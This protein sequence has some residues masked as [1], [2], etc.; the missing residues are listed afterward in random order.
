M[1]VLLEVEAQTLAEGREWTRQRLEERLQAQADQI[2]ALCPQSG[3]VL[4]YVR[5][6]EFS[7][8]T[9]V[10]TVKVRAA[11]GFSSAM[12]RWLS[13]A[14][15]QWGLSPYERVSP[16]LQQKL[17]Y[18]ATQTGSYQKAALLAGCW[19]TTI[20]DDLVHSQVQSVGLQAEQSACDGPEP[21]RSTKNEAPFSLVIMLDGWMVRERGPQ[22]AAPP[23]CQDAQRV[24][25]HEVKSGVI[26]RLDHQ[27]QTASGRG[28]LTQKKVVACPPGTEVLEFGAAVQ[29]QALCCGMARAQE[30]FVVVDGALWLWSLIEDRF[31]GTTQTLD[32]YHAS[33]RLW[34]LAHYLYP[35]D[36]EAAR[37]FVEPLLHQL[38]HG[39]SSRVITR[40]EQILPKPSLQGHP[41]HDDCADPQL[42]RQIQYF[43]NHRD[44]LD[45]QAV[46]ERGAPIGSG[47][48]ESQCSQ[49][50]DRF[51]R[52]GQFWTRPGL[53]NLLALGVMIQ[54]NTFAYLWN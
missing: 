33:Q 53:R 14:R 36:A 25:W 44:H 49:F 3:L 43:L 26:Y 8:M 42:E 22:W 19:G 30:V 5:M 54:N 48:V 17:C 40:L 51:K 2:G 6:R 15:E 13:P 39:E 38:R 45:Y 35:H 34:E 16:Q 46:A 4:K 28:A 12:Q 29:Q 23:D 18:T 10:G 7:L 9:C 20:S 21:A 37:A 24:E 1:K 32:F 41:A 31:S 47:A 52:T 50:Q 11:Y 27:A